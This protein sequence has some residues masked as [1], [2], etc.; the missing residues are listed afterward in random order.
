MLPILSKT[1]VLQA[2][3][4]AILELTLPRIG[5]SN[6]AMVSLVG[7]EPSAQRLVALLMSL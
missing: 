6:E 4:T 2:N 1:V 5:L 3:S 7:T